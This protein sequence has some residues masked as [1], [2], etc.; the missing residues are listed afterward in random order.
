MAGKRKIR[1]ATYGLMAEFDNPSDAVAAARRVH[2]EGY[3]RIDA[4]SPYPVEELSEAIG[5]HKT[6]MAPVVLT[7]GIL[8]GLAGYLLQFYVHT[9]YYPINV[10]GKP[11]HS[12]PAFIPITF[13]MTVLGAALFAVFGM[14]AM[15]GLP[16]PYHPVFNAPNFALASRDRFFVLIESTD[17][18]FDRERTAEFLRTLGPREVTDVEH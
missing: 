11:L 12:W 4:F 7:G 14:L 13:E 6:Y 9:I 2:E 8:G 3:K 10:G 1:P 5:V 16:E 17:P 18:K 15:N